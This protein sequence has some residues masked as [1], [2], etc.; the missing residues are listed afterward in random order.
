MNTEHSSPSSQIDALRL[1][2][3]N[4]QNN[5][6][7]LLTKQ[8]AESNE[9][10]TD[11]EMRLKV[12]AGRNVTLGIENDKFER[13]LEVTNAELRIA[14]NAV[15]D[16]L[17][18]ASL[19]KMTDKAYS[20][21]GDLDIATARIERLDNQLIVETSKK[22][23]ALDLLST[24]NAKL[25]QA[26]RKANKL[27]DENIA[28]S[29]E[30][31]DSSIELTDLKKSVELLTIERDRIKNELEGE[32]TRRENFLKLALSKVPVDVPVNKN[33][34]TALIQ[35]QLELKNALEQIA[36]LDR[37]RTLLMEMNLQ[38]LSD[39]NQAKYIAVEADKRYMSHRDLRVKA[40]VEIVSLV[41]QVQ[42][43]R[44][45]IIKVEHYNGL[46]KNFPCFSYGENFVYMLSLNPTWLRSKCRDTTY[47]VYMHINEFGY[48]NLLYV[49]DGELETLNGKPEFLHP[50]HIKAIT[51]EIMR[52]KTDALTM[53][54]NDGAAMAMN[55]AA[56]ASMS[57]CGE[58]YDH[59]KMVLFAAQYL[60]EN[61]VPQEP[62]YTAALKIIEGIA[63]KHKIKLAKLEAKFKGQMLNQIGTVNKAKSKPKR[64]RSKKR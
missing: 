48:G 39:V 50:S 21:Q 47:P 42:Q 11:F 51:N 36:E 64:S 18:K 13:E 10:S 38:S 15:P 23:K 32:P 29:A 7:T 9:K 25:T 62:K 24:T 8:L 60:E 52:F 57:P 16:E 63:S 53:M 14:L 5:R 40:E 22:T 34:E 35:T 45:H 17:L 19:T 56:Q 37:D 26:E 30:C 33:T 12:A 6:I 20:V 27:D 49:N 59:D 28:L 1:S 4:D 46:L 41:S 55:L 44:S 31:R 2:V 43:Y 54:S 61:A 58:Y 3:V